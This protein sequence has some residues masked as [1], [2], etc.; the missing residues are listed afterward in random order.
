[1]K[2]ANRFLNVQTDRSVI[3]S[4]PKPQVSTTNGLCSRLRHKAPQL[5]GFGAL[6]TLRPDFI[7]LLDEQREHAFVRLCSTTTALCHSEERSD[8]ESR[9]SDLKLQ[10]SNEILRSLRSLR[11]TFRATAVVVVGKY[12][13]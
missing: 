13:N 4:G 1:M 10:R 9:F 3:R 5:R 12:K 7:R 11:M 2:S 8:E 6:A